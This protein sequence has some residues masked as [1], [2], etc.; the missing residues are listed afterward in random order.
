MCAIYESCDEA[1]GGTGL[2]S[3]T[4]CVTTDAYEVGVNA[5]FAS[6]TVC[7]ATV[8]SEPAG[9]CAA[10]DVALS[11]NTCGTGY[12]CNA[13]SSGDALCIRDQCGAAATVEVC[14][15]N[16]Q[17]CSASMQCAS[18]ACDGSGLCTGTTNLCV[19]SLCVPCTASGATACAVPNT[20]CNLLGD[21]GVCTQDC[22]ENANCATW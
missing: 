7:V 4:A 14:P 2:C 10:C 9:T 19:D 3:A 12:T 17:E 6:G 15:L 22:T 13:Q 16:Y 8:G 1:D 21:Y 5:C 20:Y 18:I 11:S